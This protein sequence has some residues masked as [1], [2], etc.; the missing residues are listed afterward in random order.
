MPDK[1]NWV[2]VQEKTFLRWVN[3]KLEQG[4][5]PSIE[6]LSDL[7]SGIALCNLLNILTHTK[8]TPI[9]EKPTTKFQCIENLDR[10]LEFIKNHENLQVYNIGAEDIVDGNLKLTLGL[11][12]TIIF[13]YSMAFE[14]KEGEDDKEYIAGHL[15]K[16]DILLRWTQLVTKDL[17]DVEIKNFTTSWR[18]GLALA[19]ILSHFEPQLM[20]YDDFIAEN[21]DNPRQ[22]VELVM[23]NAEKA[24]GIH[25][26]IDADDLVCEK[27]DEKCIIAYISIWYDKLHLREIMEFQKENMERLKKK[28]SE[29]SL[30]KA[31]E[32]ADRRQVGSR[33]QLRAR[34]E[35][36]FAVVGNIVNM[37]NKFLLEME[38]LIIKMANWMAQLSFSEDEFHNVEDVL[39][40]RKGLQQYRTV[41][42]MEIFKE[43]NHLRSEK[44]KLNMCLRDYNFD[45]F[46]E[47][48][49]KSLDKAQRLLK[50]LKVF[51]AEAQQYVKDYLD[52]KVDEMTNNFHKS[53]SSIQLG[54][55][56][57]E[58]ELAEQ[59][60]DTKKQLNILTEVMED[61]KS[62]EMMIQRLDGILKEI[63]SL[64]LRLNATYDHNSEDAK[65]GRFRAKIDYLQKLVLDRLQFIDKEFQNKDRVFKILKGSEEL[66]EREEV[67]KVD[68]S[69]HLPVDL[70]N[71]NS[72][73]DLEKYVF[74]R[75]DEGNKDYLNK[76]EF[77]EAFGYLYPRLSDQQLED[78][79][80]IIYNSSN[81]ILR[82]VRFE[83]FARLLKSTPEDEDEHEEKERKGPMGPISSQCITKINRK[84]ENSKSLSSKDEEF[85]NMKGELYLNTF[86]E[87]CNNRDFIT[88]GDLEK[89][90]VDKRLIKRLGDVMAELDSDKDQNKNKSYDYVQFFSDP[91]SSLIYQ[92]IGSEKG[93]TEVKGLENI[94]QDLEKVDLE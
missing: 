31:L 38:S 55:N 53:S 49:Q 39:R 19:A 37:K 48:Q 77:K 51:E 86:R 52:K 69:S 18:N 24:L 81:L 34:M 70:E 50:Q 87:A 45:S 20:N 3:M 74:D 35:T 78:L 91:E 5:Y 26:L 33:K 22:I 89:I 15:S 14:E 25:R 12:W 90:E 7:A 54:L 72:E 93:E 10:L 16:K 13:R 17:K 42:K 9:Y 82:G 11:L 41:G 63:D 65:V 40:F 30:K 58:G 46:R 84:R 62:L 28:R 92:D 79:F 44:V 85:A 80:E 60:M 36:F 47:P 64:Y 23:T 4:R 21:A 75:F 68:L 67:G 94:L 8:L 73:L 57:I 56:L 66:K 61:L 6:K 43:L 1:D 59:H 27:P 76:S 2:S 88:V 32:Q 71:N 29:Q 83:D